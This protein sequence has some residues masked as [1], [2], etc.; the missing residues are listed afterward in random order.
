MDLD[1]YDRQLLNLLQQDSAPTAEG[2]AER[3]PL[4]SS[5][6]QRRVKRLKDEGYI[7]TEVAVV[8]PKKVGRPTFFVVSLEIERERPELLASLRAWLAAQEEIQQA[9]YVTGAADFVLVLTSPDAEAYD[10][11]MNRLVAENPNVRRFTTNV[12]LGVV[13]RSL[14]V[15]VRSIGADG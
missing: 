10:A 6:I 8:D 9:Y 5:A 12:A 2:L 13:K 14:A 4:S 1:R 7:L 11:F 3:V 15:P